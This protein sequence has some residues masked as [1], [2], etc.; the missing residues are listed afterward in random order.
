MTPEQMQT[1]L[2]A[3]FPDGDIH[4]HDLTGTQD[5]YEVRVISKAFKGQSRIECQRQVMAAFAAELKSG[6][7][8]A[9]TIKTV[10]K[11]N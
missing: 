11:E 9:L 2:K 7:V 1:R 3:H 10:L 4:V 6:E 5:H 8:H